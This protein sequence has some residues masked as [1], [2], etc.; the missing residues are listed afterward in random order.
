MF[1]GF[2]IG[3]L[4]LGALS[5]LYIGRRSKQNRIPYMFFSKIVKKLSMLNA[6]IIGTCS[7]LTGIMALKETNLLK[8]IQFL[9]LK[10][11]FFTGNFGILFVSFL[12]IVLMFFQFWITWKSA[13]SG[14]R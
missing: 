1:M 4:A 10:P 7:S 14:Y 6:M 2:P 9:G 8:S 13:L 3:L 11:D 5:G 12:T